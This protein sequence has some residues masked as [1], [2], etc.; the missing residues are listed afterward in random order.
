ME[1]TTTD[2]RAQ[3]TL[4]FAIAMGVFLLAVAF[5][6][7]FIPSLTAP[8]VDGNQEQS[9]VADRVASNLV[10]GSLADPDRPYVLN[11]TCT[12]GFF[13]PD[14]SATVDG[15]GYNTSTDKFRKR[16]GVSDRSRVNITIVRIDAATRDR[17]TLC[18]DEDN[19]D[20]V[21]TSDS[22]CDTGSDV[23]YRI[24]GSHAN[25]ESVTV[26]RRIVSIDGKDATLLVRVW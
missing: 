14:D 2:R 15:C 13:E 4:D 24:G 7:T 21:N 10:E 11:V 18:Y 23:V 12:T 1:P 6:F 16:I 8:F 17:T 5:V 25:A 26:A 9:A 19:D 22:E 20:L 3:T